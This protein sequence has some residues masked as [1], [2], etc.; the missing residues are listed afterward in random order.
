MVLNPLDNLTEHS[1]GLNPRILTLIFLPSLSELILKLIERL[2]LD[3]DRWKSKSQ[4]Y[5]FYVS[6]HLGLLIFLLN[7]SSWTRRLGTIDQ[8][9]SHHTFRER[10]CYPQTSL[11]LDFV[12]P[13][14]VGVGREYTLSL[15][16]K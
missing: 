4:L 14:R 13:L 7:F 2:M 10:E 8:I 15:A 1:W 5:Y 11:G 3:S 16:E 9:H 12:S 6:S